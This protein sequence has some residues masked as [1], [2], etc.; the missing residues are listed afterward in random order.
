PTVNPPRFAEIFRDD[1]PIPPLNSKQIDPVPPPTFPSA[2]GPGFAA[3]IA[4]E[5]FSGFTWKPLTSLSSPSHVSPTTGGDDHPEPS[6]SG[7]PC[8]ILHASAASRTTPTLWVLVRSTGPLS[9][10]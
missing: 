2:T 6:A 4:R 8:L 1:V 5:T 9:C 10:P 3:S 7:G